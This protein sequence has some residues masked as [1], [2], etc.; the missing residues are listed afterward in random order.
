MGGAL[1][2]VTPVHPAATHGSQHA[3]TRVPEALA[4][5]SLSHRLSQAQPPPLRAQQPSLAALIRSPLRGAETGP[6]MVSVSPAHTRILP[7]WST[8]SWT[9]SRSPQVGASIPACSNPLFSGPSPQGTPDTPT[10]PHPVTH[11]QAALAA[12]EEAWAQDSRFH[13]QK[14]DVL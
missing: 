14:R 6:G 8:A 12:P 11:V 7:S 9:K 13:G 1:A 4:T 10:V 3:R 2:V 5:G